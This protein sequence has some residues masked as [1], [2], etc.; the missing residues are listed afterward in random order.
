MKKI[1]IVLMMLPL[2]MFGQEIQFSKDVKVETGTP[3]KVIDG[4]SKT[5]FTN[6][7]G[8]IISV[9]TDKEEAYI[10]IFDK[11]S[12]KEISRKE[13]KDFPK[14]TKVQKV[15]KFGDRLFYFYAVY[16]KKD[17]N[18]SV[19][20]REVNMDKGEFKTPEFLFK[21]SGVVLPQT[22]PERD[23]FWGFGKGPKFDFFNSFDNSKIMIQYRVKP[24]KKRD[25]ISYDVLGFYVFNSEDMEKDW[26][27][28][29]KMPYT[30]K[31]M[32]NIAYTVSS[33][34]I[35]YMIAYLNDQSSFELLNIKSSST[36][37]ET[38][39]M[40]LSDSRFYKNLTLLEDVDGNLN[41]VGFYANGIEFK[42][43]FWGGSGFVMNVNGFSQF[44]MTTE[45]E[46]ISENKIDF[47]VEIINQFEKA[48]KQKKN[49]KREAKGKLGIQDIVLRDVVE[50]KDGSTIVV[51]EQYFLESVYNYMTKRNEIYY[52]YED[53]VITKISKDGEIIWMKKLAK[54]Q[55]GKLGKGGMSIKYL[56][57]NG[58]HYILFLDNEKNLT[59][60]LD[61]APKKHA[62]GKGGFLTAYKIDDEA[63]DVKKISI[64]DTRDMNGLN[65][66]QFKTS[67]LLLGENNK[68]FLEVY[69]K[70]KK[71][72]QQKRGQRNRNHCQ[73]CKHGNWNT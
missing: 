20:L 13:Y 70:G 15:V 27:K 6:S 1:I 22:V 34:G 26:G 5:Y 65:A 36:K 72:I 29:I 62:D 48:R 69:I 66:Y 47:P 8:N 7:D 23:G 61:E 25:K 30:E 58:K 67:R 41:C 12:L 9:K 10:Q 21:T 43:N 68:L 71:D 3:Y 42:Y 39:K 45:G 46:I 35:A 51:G 14:Y 64:L 24:T 73:Q 19:Y 4:N 17:K 52:H 60:G 59:L 49:N 55:A 37:V 53:V 33:D 11:K 18:E 63:G 2:L 16:N 50:M 28:E 57:N 44:S 40:E 54:Y 38:N 56:E 32:N 31:E